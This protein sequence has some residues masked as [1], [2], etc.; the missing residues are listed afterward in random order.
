[1][2]RVVLLCVIA[3]SGCA[4]MYELRADMLR[5][6]CAS[7]G[8]PVGHELHGECMLRLAE[9]AKKS[10]SSAPGGD[11]EMDAYGP[12]IHMDEYGRA[13]RTVPAW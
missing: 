8:F 7:L 3:L 5:S 13:V 4:G 9:R 12:G 6:E 10:P 2:F 1:M 11:L